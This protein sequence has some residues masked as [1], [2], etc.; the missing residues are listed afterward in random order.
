[1]IHSKWLGNALTLTVL[2]L[3]VAC[4]THTSIPLE[5]TALIIMCENS[6]LFNSSR[7]SGTILASGEHAWR[8]QDDRLMEVAWSDYEI[9]LHS[10]NQ[11]DW[12]PYTITFS[13][14][15]LSDDN[16]IQV[17]VSILYDTGFTEDSRGGNSSIW[18]LKYLEGQWQV[19]DIAEG[20][21]WD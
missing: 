8:Y 20:I 15:P 4:Q 21:S 13:V 5:E 1:M 14:S 19:I 10:S 2:V 11:K 16:S 6:G 17:E 3:T 9:A 7:A 12:P 18:K